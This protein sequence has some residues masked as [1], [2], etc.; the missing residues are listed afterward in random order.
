MQ[1]HGDDDTSIPLMCQV[2]LSLAL[3]SM[4]FS[5][6]CYVS[7]IVANTYFLPGMPHACVHCA[8][9]LVCHG[10]RPQVF[11]PESVVKGPASNSFLYD[12][13]DT[14]DILR[15]MRSLLRIY[16]VPHDEICVL[17][18]AMWSNAISL[19]VMNWAHRE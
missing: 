19:R 4:L 17:I 2:R 15:A 10:E 12:W 5:S 3:H 9:T 18:D 16:P 7:D 14:A 6:E 11:H 1:E 13:S 8:W